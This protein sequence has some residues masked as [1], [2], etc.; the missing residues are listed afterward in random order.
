MIFGRNFQFSIELKDAFA[1]FD[2]LGGGVISTK[3]LAYV[4]R[5]IGYQTSPSE[6]EQMIREADQDGSFSDSLNRL[7]ALLETI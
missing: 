2:R 4:M 3:D 6:I 5:S 1:L 7:I